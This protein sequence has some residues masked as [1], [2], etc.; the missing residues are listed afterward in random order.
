MKTVLEGQS[1]G[2]HWV[3]EIVMATRRARNWSINI[4]YEGTRGT[5]CSGFLSIN[6]LTMGRL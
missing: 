4:S 6:K 1:I 5:W 3:R 2:K